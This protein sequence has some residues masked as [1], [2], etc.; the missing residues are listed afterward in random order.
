M[1]SPECSTSKAES[2]S[3]VARAWVGV[4]NGELWLN[5]YEVSILQG[6]KALEMN[7]IMAMQQCECISCR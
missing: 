3:L 4:G 6:E 2:R 5:G 1:R 7:S